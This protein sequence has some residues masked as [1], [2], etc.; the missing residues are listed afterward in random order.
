MQEPLLG[1]SQ[2]DKKGGREMRIKTDRSGTVTVS[3][4]CR[5][6]ILRLRRNWGSEAIVQRLSIDRKSVEFYVLYT[7]AVH[8]TARILRE[9]TP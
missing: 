9:V 1:S 8:Y 3:D 6:P 2:E 4:R 7:G 5:K